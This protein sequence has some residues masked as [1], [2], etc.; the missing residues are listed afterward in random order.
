[1]LSNGADFTGRP[2]A[3]YAVPPWDDLLEPVAVN[4]GGP[5]G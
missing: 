3:V 5:S 2:G 4:M 1:M